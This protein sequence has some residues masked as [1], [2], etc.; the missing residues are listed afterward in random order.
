MLRAQNIEKSLQKIDELL[1]SFGYQGLNDRV[2]SH[3]LTDFKEKVEKLFNAPLPGEYTTFLERV[4]GVEFNGCVLFGVDS[5][6]LPNGFIRN[7]RLLRQMQSDEEYL[8]LGES[9]VAWFV[10][11]PKTRRFMELDNPSARIMANFSSFDE[12]LEKFLNDAL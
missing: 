6:D 11:E 12:M 10:Y 1:K 8:F 2:S 3:I 7:N 9:G 5:K 4:N